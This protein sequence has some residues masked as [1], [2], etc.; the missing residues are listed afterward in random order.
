M[1]APNLDVILVTPICSHSLTSRPI[2]ASYD[3]EVVVKVLSECFLSSDG[4]QL[5]TLPEGSEVRIV[6]SDRK[7]GF[8]RFGERNIFKLM[9][10]RLA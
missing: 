3:S 8:I 2:V 5:M 4:K 6:K 7:V 10:E 9:R 1:V